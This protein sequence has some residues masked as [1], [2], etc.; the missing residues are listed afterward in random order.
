MNA[1]KVVDV[2]IL[3][4]FCKLCKMHE[5]DDDTLENSAWKIDHKSKCKTNFEGSAPALE[6]E[7][8]RRIV[9]RFVEGNKLRYIE[10]FAWS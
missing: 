10:Y 3:S 6:P 1:G 5:N 8:G 2:E 7:G 4:K 9:E